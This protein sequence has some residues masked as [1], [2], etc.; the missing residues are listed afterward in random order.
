VLV[1][2]VLA[3]LGLFLAAELVLWASLGQ[4][5]ATSTEG[6]GP[7]F[8][9]MFSAFAAAAATAG[10]VIITR[11]PRNTIGWL[12]LAIP[13]CA[14]FALMA[15]DYAT[16]A[17][18][19]APGSLPVGTAAAWIDRWAIVPMLCLPI[20][21]F[22]LFPDGRVPSGRW[23]PV[24]WLALAAPA[25][26]T[27]LFALTPGRM[28]GGFAQLTSVR[29]IN[30]LGIRAAGGVIRVLSLIGGF[31]CLLA[32]FLAGAALVARFR[33]RRGDERQ[34]VK[35]LAFAGTAFLA[36][37]A[38]TLVGAATLGNSPAGDTWG[39]TMYTVMFATLAL[40][41]P[42]ACAVA[43]LKYRLYG[44]DVVISKT[45]VYA[46]LA[47]FITAVYV[48]LVAGAGALAGPGGR[49]SLGLSILATAVVAV[50]FQP[51][52]ERVQRFAN[53]LVY[54]R[55]ATP[56]EALAQLSERM[57]GTYATEDLLPTMARIV[58]EAT[59]AAR[60]DV[61]LRDGGELRAVASW[62]AG[63]D[64]RPAVALAGGEFPGRGADRRV[65]VMH[66]G[67]LLGALS[68]TKK[69]GDAFTPTEDKLV[70]DLATQ[71]GLMLRNVGLTEQLLARLAELRTSRERLVTAQDRERQRLERDIRSGAQ[72]QL[73]GLVGK[74]ELAA[75][76]LEHDEAHAK[77]LLNQVTSHTAQ[78]LKDLRELARGI[79]PALLADLG[80]AAALDAQARKTPIPVSVEAG[81]IGRYPQETEA[82]VYFCAVEA[83]R[84]A[85][86]HA[87]ASRASVRLSENNAELR[88]EVTDN[89]QG[90]DP[91]TTQQGT[92][93]QGM[94]DRID[95]LGG[96]V[97]VDSGP[98]QGTRID[99][100]IPVLATT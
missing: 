88:F 11:Q 51:V 60:A 70:S 68:I 95:A 36:E 90:F 80:I 94:A 38:L 13:V 78:A 2:T 12:L 92:G 14:A 99:G 57:A 37:F 87:H 85:A 47:A 97:N 66:H 65:P 61:W 9:V 8:V 15:G 4:L 67:E 7:F 30:P 77:A 41:I 34:Q 96:H 16:Y 50:A 54:G 81:G 84:N 33:S 40:G 62:P 83:L 53:R 5:Q 63:A 6:N 89:G 44:I 74:L 100:Q 31:S 93:L 25:L 75:Q 64:P 59:G 79:Y 23:R 10:T 45:V 71:A 49:P 98:G 22:L 69:R 82:A 24:L 32:A 46:V 28:T 17:L 20:L 52:R 55:R 39:N 1:V 29:V 18:V 56:Y 73:A 72:R 42:A 48:L 86:K 27:A 19:T 21:L 58:A 76:A 91:A 43:I 35:W 3:A 26:T